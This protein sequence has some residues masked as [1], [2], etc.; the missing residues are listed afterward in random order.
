[1]QKLIFIVDDNDACL[2]MAASA[3]ESEYMVLTVPS[4]EKMFSLLEKKT[5]DLI[6]LDILMPGMGGFDAIAKLK[7]HPVWSKI[8]VVFLTGMIDDG[9]L[10]NALKA[11][12]LDVIS[13]NIESAALLD[14]VN[15]HLPA[16]GT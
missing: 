10:A 4:A 3:L 6:L 16:S 7:E 11:G 12:A 8:P 9:L 15:K 5:P 1:M 13:K 14:S 2:T